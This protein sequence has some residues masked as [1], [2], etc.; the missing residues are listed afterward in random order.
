MHG[1]MNAISYIKKV[2]MC[3]LHGTCEG[4]FIFN[5]IDKIMSIAL[6]CKCFY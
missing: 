3:L 2:H 1:N 4:I 5:Y 6:K